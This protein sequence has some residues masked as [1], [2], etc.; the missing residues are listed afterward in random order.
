MQ[1]PHWRD[2]GSDPDSVSYTHLTHEIF[3]LLLSGNTNA[4]SI[5]IGEKGADM[6][7]QDR[8]KIS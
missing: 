5:V 6:I 3:S 1:R 8:E 2:H 4:G 7:M